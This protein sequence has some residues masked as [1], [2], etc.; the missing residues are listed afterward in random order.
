VKAGVW[1]GPRPAGWRIAATVFVGTIGILIPGV[2]PIV[3]GALL[4]EQHISLSQLGHAA[5]AELLCM[6]LAAALAAA[7]LPPRRLRATGIA[8]S[9]ILALV[10]WLTPLAMGETVTA[11]RAVT[12]AA[13]GVLIWVTACLIARS[14]APERWAGIYLTVQTLAQFIFAAT[15]AS[16]IEPRWAAL[17]DFALLAVAGFVSAGVSLALPTAFHVLP[18]GEGEGTGSFVMP[19]PRGLAAL[20]SIFLL[21]MFIVSIWVYYD[22]IARQAGL[23]T[24]IS[25]EA[26]SVSLGFQVLGGTLATLA[27]GRLKWYP[28]F[29]VCAAVDLIMVAL[30]GSRP[31]ALLFLFDAAVFGFIWMFILPFLVSMIIEA[32][33]SRRSA[34]FFSGVALLGAS[35]GPTIVGLIISP[36]ETAGAL[37]FGAGCLFLSLAIATALRFMEPRSPPFAAAEASA[38]RF[39]GERNDSIN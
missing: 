18:K 26:V 31:S 15:M 30:L 37:W 17:G 10:N 39:D 7:L 29:L 21:L 24:Q 28:V 23:S 13:G 19:P 36:D 34:V 38:P 20:A 25:D 32:D 5:S 6:G 1:I 12:G 9:L 35:L 11:L 8:A 4:T 22:P 27:A 2:Q 3:L 33:P 14:A 16:W